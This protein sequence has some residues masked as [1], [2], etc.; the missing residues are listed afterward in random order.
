VVGDALR[1]QQVLLNLAGNA[2]KFTER[3]EVVVSAQLVAQEAARCRLRL[4]SATP[5]SASR[6]SSASTSSTA[7]RRPRPR[8]RGATA[9]P[10]WD[11]RSASGWCG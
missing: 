7:F 4:P 1:L 8:P 6:P 9:A 2:I 10:G 5:A 11:W 3:G